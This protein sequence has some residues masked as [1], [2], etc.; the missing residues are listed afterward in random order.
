M[1]N[2]CLLPALALGL[3]LVLSSPPQAVHAVGDKGDKA[4][5]VQQLIQQLG[6]PKFAVRDRAKKELESMGPAASRRCARPPRAR[7]WR[8]AAAPANSSGSWKTR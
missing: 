7:T 1:W 6:S 3:T 5:R 4:D 8:P 2:R